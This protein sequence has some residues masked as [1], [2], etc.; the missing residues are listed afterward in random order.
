MEKEGTHAKANPSVLPDGKAGIHASAGSGNVFHDKVKIVGQKNVFIFK[1]KEHEINVEKIISA[2]KT[3]KITWPIPHGNDNY[4]EREGCTR[5][6]LHTIFNKPNNESTAILLKGSPGVGKTQ[7]INAYLTKYR[8]EYDFIIW[9]NSSEDNLIMEFKQLLALFLSVVDINQKSKE[10]I[11][12]LE[13]KVLIE[14]VQNILHS[15][16]R[17]ILYLFDNADSYQ[18]VAKYIPDPT[19][20]DKCITH[21]LITSRR[22]NNWPSHIIKKDIDIYSEQESLNYIRKILPNMDGAIDL[23]KLLKRHPLSIAQAVAYIVQNQLKKISIYIELYEVAYNYLVATN[24]LPSDQYQASVLATW[25]SIKNTINLLNPLAVELIEICSYLNGDEI[26]EMLFAQYNKVQFYEAINILYNYCLLIPIGETNSAFR[27]HKAVQ[28]CVRLWQSDNRLEILKKVQILLEKAIDT[29]HF[30]FDLRKFKSLVLIRPRVKYLTVQHCREYLEHTINYGSKDIQ[31]V[32]LVLRI[33][34]YSFFEGEN[35]DILVNNIKRAKDILTANNQSNVLYMCM[36][37]FIKRIVRVAGPIEFA[38][39]SAATIT[40]GL[41]NLPERIESEIDLVISKEIDSI[42]SGV[43]KC[44][45]LKINYIG[46]R[47]FQIINCTILADQIDIVLEENKKL[48]I[49]GVKLSSPRLRIF[50]HQNSELICTDS[51]LNIESIEIV[52]KQAKNLVIAQSKIGSRLTRILC[53]QNSN[54]IFKNNFMQAE[55]TEISCATNSCVVMGFNVIG[56]KKVS[57]KCT[58]NS[59]FSLIESNIMADTMDVTA[60]KNSVAD[61]YSKVMIQCD[62]MNIKSDYAL[63]CNSGI[64]IVCKVFDMQVTG[65]AL[66]SEAYINSNTIQL[67]GFCILSKVLFIAKDINSSDKLYFIY[68]QMSK[69]DVSS[70]RLNEIDV[71][72]Y[73]WV[74]GD[75]TLN[76]D[77]V[78]ELRPIISKEFNLTPDLGFIDHQRV[79]IQ[80]ISIIGIVIDS[81]PIKP[82]LQV[83]L[84]DYCEIEKLRYVNLEF[85]DG[86]GSIFEKDAN[87]V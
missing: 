81:H 13:D 9:L 41:Y 83:L 77:V 60:N 31:L 68:P 55:S 10:Y 57:L 64:L 65:L 54:L 23:A 86:Q 62:V 82:I 8:K 20:K 70:G 33:L 71:I 22:Q 53:T 21:I 24:S 12:N 36:L 75:L 19:L 5:D 26:G 48:L 56:S 17:K 52:C 61:I 45:K 30:S 58:D 42:S 6:E 79:S 32:S 4:I 27:I 35:K 14:L 39:T 66:F 59:H 72:S 3:F 38:E 44:R 2:L 84:K 50:C 85:S 87:K 15:V 43:I 34:L 11:D 18:T 37:N 28:E 46:Q 1:G 51:L 16:F 78:E 47:V 29:D 49:S 69:I 80:K 63:R 7:I 40:A 74:I 73:C 67:M 76:Q 25:V